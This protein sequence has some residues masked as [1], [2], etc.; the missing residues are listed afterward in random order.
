MVFGASIAGT[1]LFFLI[2]NFGTWLTQDMYLNS[3][4]TKYLYPHTLSGLIDCYVLAIPFLKYSFMG[5]LSF[6]L[7]LFGGYYLLTRRSLK[8]KPVKA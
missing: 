6:S 4:A 1:I 8:L 7:V 3:S 5:D 2:T